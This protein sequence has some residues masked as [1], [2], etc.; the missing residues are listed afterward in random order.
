[1]DFSIITEN[2]LLYLKGMGVTLQVLFVSTAIGSAI[3]IPVAVLMLSA[4]RAIKL[5]SYSFVTFFRG[6]PL[7]I[8]L[9]LIYYGLGQ[10]A[11]VR[12]SFAWILLEKPFF[13]A[14]LAL[15]LNNAAYTAEIVRGA[16]VATPHGEIEAAHALGMSRYQSFIRIILPSALRRSIPAYSNEVIFMLHGTVVVSLVT[17]YDITGVA[18]FINSRYYSPYEAFITAAL[19]YMVITFC[20]IAIFKQIEKR[21]LAYLTHGR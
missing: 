3:G 12:E 13:C 5:S 17:L 1:M 20:L 10:F 6:T 19:L 18:R 2:Y 9:F 15:A 21:G 7:V 14:V 4:N 11:F 8:Q 16:L